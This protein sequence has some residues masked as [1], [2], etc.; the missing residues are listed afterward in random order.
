[1][2]LRRGRSRARSAAIR[3]SCGTTLLLDCNQPG[4]ELQGA[5]GIRHLATASNKFIDALTR[6]AEQP[7]EIGLL[8]AFFQVRPELRAQFTP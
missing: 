1:M 7:S 2:R 8:A 5:L 3:S 4:E 6:E